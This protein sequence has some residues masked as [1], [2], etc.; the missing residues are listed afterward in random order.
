MSSEFLGLVARHVAGAAF[1]E[2]GG[3][4]VGVPEVNRKIVLLL[5]AERA[6]PADREA[7]YR[8]G[9]MARLAGLSYK[10]TRRA[11]ASL[12]ADGH[13]IQGRR[14]GRDQPTWRLWI[15]P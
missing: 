11:V 3:R 7:W 5:V 12:V 1:V 15:A 2:E 13:L 4:K 10:A 9:E 14:R 6:F 8:I